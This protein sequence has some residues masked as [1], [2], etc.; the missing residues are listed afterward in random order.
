MVQLLLLHIKSNH[1]AQL[2]KE[3][4]GAT[5]VLLCRAMVHV[6]CRELLTTQA[7]VQPTPTDSIR[8]ENF[9]WPMNWVLWGRD[10]EK[11]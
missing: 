9:S 1:P 11:R 7:S 2:R 10:A 4:S 3:A 6:V 8:R 5:N